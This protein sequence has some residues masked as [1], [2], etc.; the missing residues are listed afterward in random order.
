MST[1]IER[2]FLVKGDY[3]KS[4]HTSYCIKQAYISKI[5][6]RTVRIRIR[7]KQGF[8]TIKGISN[9][10]G[11]SRYEFEKEISLEEAETLLL[12]CEKGIIEKIR[13][14]IEFEGNTFEVDEFHG[15]HEGLILA[16]IELK[17]ENQVFKKP[18]WLGEE[19]TG[20]KKYY[21]SYLSKE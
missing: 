2:K 4:A 9:E 7:D 1:E 16:E 20:N 14:L 15:N 19:V 3:K 12:I 10:S 21:N 6:E 5:P 17:N 8:I 11:L 18:S 13:H